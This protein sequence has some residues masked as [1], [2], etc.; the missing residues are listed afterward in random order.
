MQKSKLEVELYPVE[1][2]LELR[3]CYAVIRE[4]CTDKLL[5]SNGPY[6]DERTAYRAATRQYA[7]MG[8][9]AGRGLLSGITG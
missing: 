8:K 1:E 4:E 6:P 7:R 3:P 5:W 2:P 9:S